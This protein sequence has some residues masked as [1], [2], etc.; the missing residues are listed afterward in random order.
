[1]ATIDALALA[2]FRNSLL[3]PAL[4]LRLSRGSIG[5][6]GLLQQRRGL[7]VARPRGNLERGLALLVLL[8]GQVRLRPTIDQQTRPR[9]EQLAW[10]RQQD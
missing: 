5:L 10:G 6:V 2:C 8:L 7:R 3:H 9:L 1:M 4:R